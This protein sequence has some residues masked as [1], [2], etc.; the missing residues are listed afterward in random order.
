MPL[1]AAPEITDLIDD[2]RRQI[3]TLTRR[4]AELESGTSSG[5]PAEPQAQAG[6][7]VPSMAPSEA[8]S[9]VPSG[10]AS[11]EISEDELIAISAAL[12]AYL[13][14]RA[15]IRQIRLIGSR[16]WAQEGRASI[17]A[18]HHPYS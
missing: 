16:L 5:S 14:V 1:T 12:A 7:G 8:A 4:V 10:P 15:H 6:S 13:G 18:S 9:R 11:P 17:Q 2:L 3:E